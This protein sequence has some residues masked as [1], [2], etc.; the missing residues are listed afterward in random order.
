MF[1]IVCIF[2]AQFSVIVPLECMVATV[3]LYFHLKRE[4][5]LHA[6][7]F[8]PMFGPA[9]HYWDTQLCGGLEAHLFAT[10]QQHSYGHK[11]KSNS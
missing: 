9:G 2:V 11:S 4:W 7:F 6:Q 1:G 5:P 10:E 3:F 8:F